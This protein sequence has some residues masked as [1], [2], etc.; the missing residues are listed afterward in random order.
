MASSECSKQAESCVGPPGGKKRATNVISD[1]DRWG[2]HQSV[3]GQGK[4]GVSPRP[5]PA[6]DWGVSTSAA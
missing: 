6:D 5:G 2:E 3:D 4:G 1:G